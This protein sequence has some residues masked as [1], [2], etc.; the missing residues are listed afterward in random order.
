[1]VSNS[2]NQRSTCQNRRRHR[3]FKFHSDG[4]AGEKPF[5]RASLINRPV[6]NNI[7]SSIFKVQSSMLERF[8]LNITRP[9]KKGCIAL[10]AQKSGGSVGRL[11]GEKFLVVFLLLYSRPTFT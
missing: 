9:K 10:L 5:V 11:W 1:M 7:Q 2:T 3:L 8:N 4:F 6:N